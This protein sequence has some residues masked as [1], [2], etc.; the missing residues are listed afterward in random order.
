MRN[1]A[2]VLLFTG[3]LLLSPLAGAIR[4]VPGTEQDAKVAHIVSGAASDG[5]ALARNPGASYDVL[6]RRSIV[7]L[8][9]PLSARLAQWMIDR[10]V[11]ERGGD[12][13][14]K[15]SEKEEET[16]T[17]IVDGVSYPAT[18]LVV[19]ILIIKHR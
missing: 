16:Y 4:L 13:Y 9:G 11:R 5:A 7:V 14:I 8:N 18:N 15:V 1:A 10:A 17:E 2:S 12:A 19:E 3:L 6:E